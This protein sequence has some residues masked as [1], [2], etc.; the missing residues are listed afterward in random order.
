MGAKGPRNGKRNRF[1]TIFAN[2]IE[3][4]FQTGECVFVPVERLCAVEA[5][6][7]LKA[8]ID[9]R[10]ASGWGTDFVRKYANTGTGT[11]IEPLDSHRQKVKGTP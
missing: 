3:E 10:A 9:A 5:A 1:E 8:A 6:K 4:V 2:A 7:G 11:R